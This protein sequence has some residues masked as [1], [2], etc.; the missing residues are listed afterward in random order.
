MR[1]FAFIVWVARE[2]L[3]EEVRSEG[4]EGLSHKNIWGKGLPAERTPVQ[5]PWGEKMTVVLK[6]RQRSQ[7]GWSRRREGENR[8][9]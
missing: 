4:G 3:T 7:C 5:R 9:R 8:R 1:I 2:G 6:G